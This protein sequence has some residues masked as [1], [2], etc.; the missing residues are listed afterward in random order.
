MTKDRIILERRFIPK[1]SIIIKEGDEGYAAYLVQS[2]QVEV[3]SKSENGKEVVLATLKTGDICGEMALLGEGVRTASVRA[4]SDCNLVVI[5][6]A[7]FEEK[8]RNCDPTIQ[9][10]IR[11]MIRRLVVANKQRLA[12]GSGESAQQETN[13]VQDTDA[14]KGEPSDMFWDF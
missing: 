12:D 7:A 6:R 4:L 1:G 13:K 2:G 11:M 8:V 10:V 3:Y 9:A 5:T 14:T